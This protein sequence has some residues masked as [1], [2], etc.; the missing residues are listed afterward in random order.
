M[1]STIYYGKSDTASGEQV[2]Q[3]IVQGLDSTIT[4]ESDFLTSGD[5]LAVYFTSKNTNS[6]PYIKLY[7]ESIADENAVSGDNGNQIKIQSSV[8]DLK[9]AWSNG[10]AC[11]FVYIEIGNAFYW[12]LIGSTLAEIDVYG[13]TKLLT[14]LDEEF[15]ANASIAAGAVLDLI[16]EI[17]PNRLEYIPVGDQTK[18]IGTL[19]LINP[20][21]PES[22][23]SSVNL[24]IPVDPDSFRIYTNELINNGPKG[25]EVGE[26]ITDANIGEGYPYITHIVPNRLSFANLPDPEVSVRGLTIINGNNEFVAYEL[27]DAQNNSSINSQGNISINAAQ[28]YKVIV[29]KNNKGTLEVNYKGLFKDS[30]CIQLDATNDKNLI[31]KITNLGWKTAC[32]K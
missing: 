21:D 24:Y 31:T 11:F 14:S 25:R 23:P 9:G 8:D 17:Q 4:Q 2:K 15:D 7:K 13:S 30:L 16:E 28:N 29:G 27:A 19:K 10:E 22:E 18:Q 6:T 20:N 32:I 3:V 12:Y 26:P 1:A 5:I